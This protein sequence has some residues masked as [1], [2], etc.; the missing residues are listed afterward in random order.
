MNKQL[1]LIT[2]ALLNIYAGAQAAA[3]DHKERSQA[4]LAALRAEMAQKSVE[5]LKEERIRLITEIQR[6]NLEWNYSVT[7]QD[8]FE[9]MVQEKVGQIQINER[10][11]ALTVR[12]AEIATESEEVI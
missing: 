1:L 6:Q 4:E 12:K 11:F 5:E 10:L 3:H 7:P 2:V 9:L 8:D